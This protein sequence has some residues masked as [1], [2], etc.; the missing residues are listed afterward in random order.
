[1]RYHSF[2]SQFGLYAVISLIG[3]QGCGGGGGSSASSPIGNLSAEGVYGGTV[4]ASPSDFQ[5][6][7]LDN[8]DIWLMYGSQTSSAFIVSGFLQGSSTAS[9]GTLTISAMNDFGTTP[10]NPVSA[11]AS[12]NSS[13]KTISGTFSASGTAINFTGGPIVGSLYN[14]DSTAIQS[15]ISGAWN[16]VTVSG[17]TIA[18]S[19]SSA[20]QLTGA[21]PGGCILSGSATPRS[22]GKNV[23]NVAI[24]IGP[25]P[26]NQPNSTVSGI[27]VIY[28]L[29]S[30]KSQL[31]LAAI[32]PAKT[33]GIAAVGSR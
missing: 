4:A 30:G 15:Q 7:V 23:F 2:K 12:Y 17:A 13:L 32:N 29:S 3:L 10:P 11:T 8:G 24:N 6:L 1:M 25:S 28:P 22:S 19:I 5:M 18:L 27:A 9:N 20:G 16:V 14:Y 31:L 21:V 33:T 26:C